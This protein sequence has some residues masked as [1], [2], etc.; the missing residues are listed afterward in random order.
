MNNYSLKHLHNFLK[1]SVFDTPVPRYY[2][3]L[4]VVL[5][6][7]HHSLSPISLCK[8]CNCLRNVQSLFLFQIKK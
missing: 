4:P 2:F 7:N 8:I 6:K 5:V 3:D 1:F